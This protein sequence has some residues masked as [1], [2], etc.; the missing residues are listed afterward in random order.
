MAKTYKQYSNYLEYDSNKKIYQFNN[1]KTFFSDL[2]K[3]KSHITYKLRQAINFL[4]YNIYDPNK[5]YEIQELSI[6]ISKIIDINHDEKIDFLIPPTFLNTSISFSKDGEETYFNSL[7]SGEK[8]KIYSINSI[9]YHLSNLNSVVESFDTKLLKYRNINIV[10]DEIELYFHPELQRAYIEYLLNI[11]FVTHSPF[12]LSDL[13]KENVL[14]LDKEETDK[15]TS[16]KEGTKTF[17]ANIH[18]LLIEGFFIKDS[19]GKFSHKKVQSIVN[20][21]NEVFE[22]QSKEKKDYE[23][24]REEFIFIINSIGESYLKGILSSYIEELDNHFEY[25]NEEIELADMLKEI[26]TPEEKAELKHFIKKM[27]NKND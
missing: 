3:D 7:S 19:I 22:K 9:I 6:K 27:K 12:I 16:I 24:K 14:F 25:R 17:G 23:T 13:I 15:K 10:L 20:F 1:Y 2:E 11:I 8:Q 5:N 18:D 4:Y 26:Q 21:Y